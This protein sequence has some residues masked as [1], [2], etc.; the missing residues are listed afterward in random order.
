MEGL[1]R[2]PG[3]PPALQGGEQHGNR[4]GGKNRQHSHDEESTAQPRL[5][6]L[7][8]PLARQLLTPRVL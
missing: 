4:D 8:E 3:C 1:I 2:L 5:T 7:G 6:L